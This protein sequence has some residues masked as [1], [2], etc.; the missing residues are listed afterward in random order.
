MTTNN[1]TTAPKITA[2]ITIT[3]STT[4]ITIT[5]VGY[6]DVTPQS[7]FARSLSNLEALIGQLFLTVLVA[8]L[9]GRQLSGVGGRSNRVVEETGD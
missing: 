2:I 1:I 4:I 7:E 5:T 3:M 9:V 8:R 6:G